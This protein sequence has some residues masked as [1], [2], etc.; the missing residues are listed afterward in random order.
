MGLVQEAKKGK[1]VKVQTKDGKEKKVEGPLTKYDTVSQDDL[2]RECENLVELDSFT[3][4]LILHHIKE[5]FARGTIYTFVGSILVAV[6]PFRRL[7]VYGEDT[8]MQVWNQT[9]DGRGGGA[10]PHVFA[11]AAQALYDLRE[12]NRNQAVLISGESGAGKTET[13]K[14][15]LQFICVR[16]TA[17]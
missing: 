15:I 13:T 12:T 3:E 2:S 4:G 8:M 10:S 14:K 11:I 5:R 7:D 17:T 16:V 9:R 6:N 1:S